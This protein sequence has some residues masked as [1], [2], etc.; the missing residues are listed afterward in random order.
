M[1]VNIVS[2]HIRVCVN[3]FLWDRDSI[4]IGSVSNI[5][6][7]DIIS[8]V[9]LYGNTIELV[10]RFVFKQLAEDFTKKNVVSS[11]HVTRIIHL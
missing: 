6:L 10:A 4:R 8:L 9:N 11:K 2:T 3:T 5:K 1:C 7:L